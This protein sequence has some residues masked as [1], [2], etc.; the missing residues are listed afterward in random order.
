MI[1]YRC[2]FLL[3]S[4]RSSGNNCCKF[5]LKSW[6]EETVLWN[7][8]SL[9]FLVPTF[10]KH[11]S[12]GFSGVFFRDVCKCVVDLFKTQRAIAFNL[13]FFQLGN[14]HNYH[15]SH[16]TL[17]VIAVHCGLKQPF[18]G[19]DAH[20]F[21]QTAYLHI[22][23]LHFLHQAADALGD[24]SFALPAGVCTWNNCCMSQSLLLVSLLPS[25]LNLFTLS[26]SLLLLYK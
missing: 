24:S 13:V 3:S 8:H 25:S 10:P 9:L 2:Q 16:L 19:W 12:D 11:T 1:Q 15:T 5:R 20:K 18:E 6:K 23:S 14:L 7:S 17:M 4:S 26:L 22:C 21:L